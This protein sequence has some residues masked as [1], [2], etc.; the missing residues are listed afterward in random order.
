M[1]RR[2]VILLALSVLLIGIIV[3][4]LLPPAEPVY[5]GKKLSEWLR[6]SIKPIP[7]NGLRYASTAPGSPYRDRRDALSAI[8]AIGTNGLP[9]IRRLLC[10]RDGSIKRGLK[11]FVNTRK[12]F[13]LHLA[14]DVEK[15]NMAVQAIDTLGSD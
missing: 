2:R 9:T 14:T 4:C 11:E 12:I 10:S 1:T 3:Y 13:G 5:N 7:I 8:R 15:V 6:I